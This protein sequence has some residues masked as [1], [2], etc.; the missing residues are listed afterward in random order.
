MEGEIH[1][2]LMEPMFDWQKNS[3]RKV[4]SGRAEQTARMRWI[5]G[6]GRGVLRHQANTG[7][8]VR[9]LIDTSAG[10]LRWSLPYV[11]LQER[12]RMR[13]ELFAKVQIDLPVI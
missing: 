1:S 11:C 2:W 10:C 3:T 4:D 5:G 9:G 7:Y 6:A 8:D 12:G 13:P